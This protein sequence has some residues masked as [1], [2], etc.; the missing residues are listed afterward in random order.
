MAY[1]EKLAKQSLKNV[2]FEKSFVTKNVISID[3]IEY[4]S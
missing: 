4:F 3:N 1:I 2:T